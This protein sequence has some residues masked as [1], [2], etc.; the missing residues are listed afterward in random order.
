[1][2]CPFCK[3]DRDRVIDTRPSED[4]HVTRRRRECLECG[5]RYTTHERLEDLPLRIVKKNGQRAPFN[6]EKLLGGILRSLEK[7]P[8]SQQQAEALADEIERELLEKPEREVPSHEIG[9]MV[10]E[11][12]RG[13]DKVAYVRFASVYREFKTVDEFLKEI[14]T[15]SPRGEKKGSKGGK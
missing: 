13:V 5:R 6:R 15:I 1:M 12:L 3:L 8:V 7:R 11:K 4:G 10:M 9:G 2:R 14:K